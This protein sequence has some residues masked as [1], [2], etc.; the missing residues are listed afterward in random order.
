MTLVFPLLQ[1]L[2]LLAC[3]PAYRVA[4]R[5]AHEPVWSLFLVAPCM[6]LWIVLSMFDAGAQGL[7]NLMELIDLSLGTVLLYYLRVFVMDKF[8]QSPARNNVLIIAVTLAAT[9]LLRLYLP[10]SPELE[11]GR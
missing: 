4:S 11:G 3:L 2:I 1:F 5:H 9:V 10:V 7:S 6:I 8:N